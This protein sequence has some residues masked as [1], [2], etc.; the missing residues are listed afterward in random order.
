MCVVTQVSIQRYKDTLECSWWFSDF[1][2]DQSLFIEGGGGWGVVR[3]IFSL[4]GEIEFVEGKR[5]GGGVSRRQQSM[6]GK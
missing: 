3:K 1:L 4:E 5:R 6:K 2:G